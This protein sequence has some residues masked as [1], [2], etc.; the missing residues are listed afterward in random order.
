MGHT[1][2]SGRGNTFLFPFPTEAPCP[3][4]PQAKDKYSW[5]LLDPPKPPPPGEVDILTQLIRQKLS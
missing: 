3:T 1:V 4:S 2:S 5:G